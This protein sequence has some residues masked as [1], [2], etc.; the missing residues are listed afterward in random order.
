MIHHNF[1]SLENLKD[2]FEELE[3][4]EARNK[5]L[6]EIEEMITTS[7]QKFLTCLYKNKEFKTHNNEESEKREKEMNKIRKD[8]VTKL[9]QKDITLSPGRWL[10]QG[11]YKI[12]YRDSIFKSY[13]PEHLIK[14]D[15]ETLYNK[16]YLYS[17]PESK[18]ILDG[19]IKIYV[20]YSSQ[21]LYVSKTGDTIQ[22]AWKLK[23]TLPR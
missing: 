1:K 8:C 4:Q 17:Y 10:Q 13:D 20:K 11:R 21:A 19:C 12:E 18:E 6:L 14:Q 22:L 9:L 5:N 16:L 2:E 3:E 15:L 7:H 23:T